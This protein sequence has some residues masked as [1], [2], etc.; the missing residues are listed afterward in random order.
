MV[1]VKKKKKENEKEK[2]SPNVK[3][4]V[5]VYHSVVGV[6]GVKETLRRD[7]VRIPLPYQDVA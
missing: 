6:G 7:S 3:G 4:L 5:R 2:A 1:K